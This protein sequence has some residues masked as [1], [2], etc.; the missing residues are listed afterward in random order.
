[1]KL[2]ERADDILSG[3]AEPVLTPRPEEGREQNAYFLMGSLPSPNLTPPVAWRS[4][5]SDTP[6]V[7]LVAV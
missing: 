2:R 1:M 4:I 6:I 7:P 3:E 5:P